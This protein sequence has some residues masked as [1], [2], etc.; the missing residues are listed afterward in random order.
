[1]A[2]GENI[3]VLEHESDDEEV[4][5]EELLVAHHTLFENF[6][7]L[8]DTHKLLKKEHE[9]LKKTSNNIEDLESLRKEK[10]TLLSLNSD[11]SSEKVTLNLEIQTLKS[12]L[13]DLDTTL[14][15]LSKKHETMAENVARFNKGKG[16]LDDLLKDQIP[17]NIRKGLRFTSTSGTKPTSSK[18]GFKKNGKS[19]KRIHPSSY[20][21]H[22]PKMLNKNDRSIYIHSYFTNIIHNEDYKG[23]P[24]NT[25]VWFPKN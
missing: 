15:S 13:T 4:S 9:N 22:V 19:F 21:I 16:K 6:T 25:W 2:L 1:M 7:K 8:Y 17:K 24:N 10:D 23:K 14:T 5:K 3:A 11:L 12:R 20:Y 18:E